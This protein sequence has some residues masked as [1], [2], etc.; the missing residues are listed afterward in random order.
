MNS[1]APSILSRAHRP[2]LRLLWPRADRKRLYGD[3][4]PSLKEV[5]WLVGC[6]LCRWLLQP[7]L[8]GGTSSEDA[9]GPRFSGTTFLKLRSMEVGR[10][11]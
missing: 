11:A 4:R 3:T 9:N 2:R 6:Q 8:R 1:R 7:R 5:G 10:I